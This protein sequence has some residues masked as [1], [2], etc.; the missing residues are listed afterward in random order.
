LQ[1][2][3]QCDFCV[4]VLLNG[5]NDNNLDLCSKCSIATKVCRYAP[6]NGCNGRKRWEQEKTP[7]QKTKISAKAEKIHFYNKIVYFD[8][9]IN[10]V[11]EVRKS[12]HPVEVIF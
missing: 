11:V 4:N 3:N 9:C 6:C 5:F 1:E 10:S 2:C 7:H 8:E 12:Q